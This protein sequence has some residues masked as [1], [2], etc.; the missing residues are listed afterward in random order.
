MGNSADALVLFGASG[1]LSRRMIFPALYNL[2]RRGRLDLPVVGVARSD[3]RLDEFVGH[4]RRG[5]QEFGTHGFDDDVFTKLAERLRYVQGEY[6][7]DDTYGRLRAT[8][9]GAR[10][11]VYYLAVPPSVFPGV[12][13]GLGASGC[14]HGASVVVEKP[15]GR[16]LESAQA[17]NDALHDVFPEESILRIDHFLGKEAVLNLM[18]FRFANSFL[19]PI[20]N[21]NY[22][23]SVQITMAEDIGV[24]GRGAFYDAVGALRDVV[25]NHLFQ[26]VAFLAM[27]PPVGQGAAALLD[28]KEKVFRAMRT[29][30]PE[31]V[32]RGQYASYRDE[33]GVDPDSDTETYAAVR[34]FVDSWRWEGVPFYIRAG[35]MLPSKV[36][37]VIVRLKPPPQRVFAASEPGPVAAN[38]VRFRV[39]PDVAIAI[40]ARVKTA[41]ERMAGMPVELDLFS[42]H[43]H[44]MTAYERLIGDALEG[45]RLLFGREQS[46]LEL[47]RV[48]DR[49]VRDHGPARPY[50]PGSWGPN[51]GDALVGSDGGWVNPVLGPGPTT[52]DSAH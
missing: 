5:I 35:K 41:G 28:E 47:W 40:G 31:D 52:P 14:A 32:V 24:E 7:D 36:T 16:D 19:E 18:Y 50:A 21:R 10:H 48:V 1:D 6:D 49:V 15:F 45:E 43:A 46:I 30:A 39:S 4:A 38:Y 17:L 37:E 42:P 13:K 51:E 12:I 8:L 9:D 3:W 23:E 2:E 20:W 33:E 27:E 22:V 44:E 25:Q 29:L 26:M 11:P 34:V